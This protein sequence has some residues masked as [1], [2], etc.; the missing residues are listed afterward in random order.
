MAKKDRKKTATLLSRPTLSFFAVVA[1][2]LETVALA[3]MQTLP[4]ISEI[5][6]VTGG[7]EFRGSR[8]TCAAA[9]RQ[10]RIASR[11]L[12]RLGI[13]QAREFGKLRHLLAR[14]PWTGVIPAEIPLRFDISTSRCRLFHTG[15]IAETAES[16][17]TDQLDGAQQELAR[18]VFL[19]L[20]ELGEGTEDTRRRATLTE[21]VR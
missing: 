18:E 14:L 11:V 19:R 2:G 5:T 4:E 17:F 8:A 13:A 10:L 1:P 6:Q 12:L 21:L 9:N 7:I 15:A 20:T 3:E 16:V